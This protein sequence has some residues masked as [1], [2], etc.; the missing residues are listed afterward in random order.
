MLLDDHILS[1]FPDYRHSMLKVCRIPVTHVSGLQ[2]SGQ[3]KQSQTA[4]SF[5]EYV[6]VVVTSDNLKVDNVI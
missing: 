2:I 3:E 4:C 5:G 6:D 1:A